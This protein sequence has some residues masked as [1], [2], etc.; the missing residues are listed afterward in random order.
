MSSFAPAYSGGDNNVRLNA[1]IEDII[2]SSQRDAICAHVGQDYDND[3]VDTSE[4]DLAPETS[5]MQRPIRMSGAPVSHSRSNASKEVSAPAL[6]SRPQRQVQSPPPACSP[7]RSGRNRVR[8]PPVSPNLLDVPILDGRPDQNPQDSLGSSNF[9][10]P[11][12]PG[13]ILEEPD[14]QYPS[15][16][17]LALIVLGICLSVFVI[18]LDRTIVTTVR[19]AMI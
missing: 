11:A 17:P 14:T 15:P 6:P 13:V 2:V 9:D 19:A 1:P 5:S 12:H 16:L 18:S 7:V 8:L 3:A 4:E 10:L